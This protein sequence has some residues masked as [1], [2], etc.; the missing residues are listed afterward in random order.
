[1]GLIDS[2]E[3]WT[4]QSLYKVFLSEFIFERELDHKI[5]GKCE[6]YQS[7]LNPKTRILKNCK[8][9]FDPDFQIFSKAI[10]NYQNLSNT[11]VLTFYG[12]LNQ[13]SSAFCSKISGN[14]IFIEYFEKNCRELL[15][16]TAIKKSYLSERFLLDFQKKLLTILTNLERKAIKFQNLALDSVLI[17]ENDQI[18]LFPECLFERKK[19]F[20]GFRETREIVYDIT[21]NM[22]CLNFNNNFTRLEEKMDLIAEIYGYEFLEE[23]NKIL[24]GEKIA[25]GI[26]E[27]KEEEIRS[28]KKSLMKNMVS[29]QDETF[30]M[31]PIKSEDKINKPNFKSAKKS[32]FQ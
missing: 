13:I 2:K 6:I 12:C 25:E 21:I 5:L 20:S 26:P 10:K 15:V 8:L 32:E 30:F 28:P 3:T 18:K 16:Q 29:F 17:G 9:S 27:K 7:L 1:M 24:S 31:S 11:N 23:L 22:A 4:N 19:T 14:S